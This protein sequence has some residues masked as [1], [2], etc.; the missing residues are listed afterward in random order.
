MAAPLVVSVSPLNGATTV[1]LGTKVTVT[2][3]QLMDTSTISDR[4]FVLTGPGQTGILSPDQFIS[5]DPSISTGREYITGTFQFATVS[6]HTVV[7]FTPDKPLRANVQYDLL[8]V[9]TDSITSAD[10]IKN[11]LDEA[12]ASSY[13]WSFTTGDGHIITP[14]VPSPLPNLVGRINPD[15]IKVIPR[16]VVGNDLSQ[17]I[18]LKFPGNI[19]G[20]SFNLADI[21]VS[22][23]AIIGDPGVIVPAGAAASATYQDD[24]LTVTLTNI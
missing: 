15:D 9:G 22:I 8:L 17:V 20:N 24:E 1:V 2:F 11:S 13:S 7:T 21:L 6:S 10:Y 23:E 14:P 3:D 16:A 5:A 18:T 4:T 19:D 12:M